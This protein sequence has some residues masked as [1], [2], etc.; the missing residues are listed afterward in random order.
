MIQCAQ[1]LLALLGG[2]G[3]LGL[4]GATEL[5]EN[6]SEEVDVGQEEQTY[7]LRTVLALLAELA[8]GLRWGLHETRLQSRM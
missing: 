3:S 5:N 4:F 2:F 6:V 7:L 8:V 1:P